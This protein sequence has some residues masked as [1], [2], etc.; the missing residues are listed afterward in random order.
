[1]IYVAFGKLGKKKGRDFSPGQLVLFFENGWHPADLSGIKPPFERR[2]VIV[3]FVFDCFGFGEVY[4]AH[5]RCIRHSL[6][7]LK[8]FFQEV[9]LAS[10]RLFLSSKECY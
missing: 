6:L 4:V 2:I 3:S 7:R 8:F 5:I 10:Y 1:L 9:A